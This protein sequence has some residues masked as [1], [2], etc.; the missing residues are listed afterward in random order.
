MVAVVLE[1]LQVELRVQELL[2]EHQPPLE[3]EKEAP[4]P[5]YY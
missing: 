5:L 4:E 2:M 3:L 1:Q